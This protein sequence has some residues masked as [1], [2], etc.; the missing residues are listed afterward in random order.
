MTSAA[1][2]SSSSPK[3]SSSLQNHYIRKRRKWPIKPF[4]TQRDEAFALRLAKLSFKQS[5]RRNKFHLLSDLI[6]SFSAYE[7]NPNPQS[8]H[9][10]F[11]ILIQKRPPNWTD[12]ISRILDHIEK[13]ESFETPESIFTDLIKFYGDVRRFDDA[14]ELFSRIPRL[15]CN[16]S[17]ELLN[18]LL[19]VLCRDEKGLEVVPQVL[20]TSSEV[21]KIRIEEST[22]GVL[23]KALCKI[24]NS[25]N[26][27]DLL[28]HMVAEGF[29]V[30]RKI[31]SLMLATMCRQINC[32]GNGNG[33][34]IM[35][36]VDDLKK[37]GFEPKRDD[38]RNVISFLVRKG[39]CKDALGL[40]KQMKSNGIRPD[41]R[42]YNLLLDGLILDRDFSRADKL[43]DELLVFGLNPDFH[44][45]NVYISGLIVQNK[46][47]DGI[48]I[49]NS[50]EE[51]GCKP[52]PSTYFSI[53]RA[54]CEVGEM[55]RAIGFVNEMRGKC[56]Q[57]N[58][59][60]YEILIDGFVS[61][62]DVN[63]A[64]SFLRKMFREKF[65][66]PRRTALGKIVNWLC[67]IGMCSKAMELLGEEV[68]KGIL[69]TKTHVF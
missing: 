23:I 62:G 25:N 46:I 51:L 59:D 32:N 30:D 64:L 3:K 4:E 27:Y 50:M 61:N 48:R 56:M 34:D 31:Y 28:N 43:F 63:G 20:V 52:A 15:R 24:G 9:L 41:I 16:P 65:F 13:V 53:L 66:V 47:D 39:K 40:F 49:F 11:K 44:T 8:Y 42:C 54:L 67:E 60:M 69:E 12:Q 38:F 68:V 17:V 18:A 29:G 5:I 7:I 10:L 35:R 36:F 33:N 6:S 26:A 45:Y 55:G 19:T 37:L 14:V 21:M 2:F 58:A 57:I 1:L 22:F